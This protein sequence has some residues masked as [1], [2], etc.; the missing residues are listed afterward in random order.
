M[1]DQTVKLAKELAQFGVNKENFKKLKIE[2]NKHAIDCCFNKGMAVG[3][4][5]ETK[6]PCFSKLWDYWAYNF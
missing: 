4:T 6:V 2:M 1:F 5:A 3:V